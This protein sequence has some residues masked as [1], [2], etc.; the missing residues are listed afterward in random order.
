MK[1]SFTEITN[2]KSLKH[3]KLD[4]FKD[5]NLLF[6]YNNSGKS[7]FLQ[8]LN[9]VFKK[10]AGGEII[11]VQENG[12]VKEISRYQEGVTNFWAGDLLDSQFIYTDNT[13]ESINIKITVDEI[14]SH[15][16]KFKEAIHENLLLKENY[17]QKN[18]DVPEKIYF[19]LDIYL[20][21]EKVSQVQLNEVTINDNSV[22]SFDGTN[23]LY[24]K[25]AKQPKLRNNNG[26]FESLLSYFNDSVLFI[27][28][29]R[30]FTHEA[31]N[32]KNAQEE[33]LLSHG[34]KN[35]L[36]KKQMG[37]GT[38]KDVLAFQD[39]LKNFKIKDQDI[40][41][42]KNNIKYYPLG[43]STMH[44]IN[45]GEA[46]EIMFDKG[47]IMLPINN[48]GTGIQ[49]TLYILAKIFF[50]KSEILAIEELELN[51]SPRF[52]E[53][54]LIHLN[55]LIKQKRISQLYFSSHSFYFGR[56]S[57]DLKYGFNDVFLNKDGYTEFKYLDNSQSREAYLEKY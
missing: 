42:L 39:F 34:F 55:D 27:D 5:I 56:L 32:D 43:K 46:L 41:R 31:M 36:F 38:H 18:N 12:A 51:L 6:G 9:L 54:L 19:S 25:D 53:E 10:K 28:S 49:Q 13:D 40:Q 23:T 30:Y 8:L 45:L 20:K 24:F 57:H 1:I 29:N 26:V 17:L 3:V 16:T 11:K 52:Q 44:F 14:R 50:S 21:S 35:W 2:F 15:N 33:E 47:D 4:I 37:L 7:N 22:F 48:F